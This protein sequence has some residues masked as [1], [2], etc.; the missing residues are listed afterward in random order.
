MEHIRSQAEYEL[1]KAQAAL[2]AARAVA[3][4]IPDLSAVVNTAR[5]R[6]EAIDG[7]V[8]NPPAVAPVAIP[9]LQP[10]APEGMS[11]RQSQSEQNIFAPGKPYMPGTD[12]NGSP[13]E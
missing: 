8:A 11:A 12:A 5:A 10:A 3:S 13:V 2:D 7:L 4:T 6:L 9:T 1:N